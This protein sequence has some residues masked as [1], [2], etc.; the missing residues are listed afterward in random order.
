[1]ANSRGTSAA[2]AKYSSSKGGKVRARKNPLSKDKIN[3]LGFRAI[4]TVNF[5]SGG[6]Y[7]GWTKIN[8]HHCRD[9]RLEKQKELLDK[10]KKICICRGVTA[11]TIM[12]AIREGALSFEALRRIIGTGTGNCKAKRCRSKIDQRIKDYKNTLE[13]ENP[14]TSDPKTSI[15]P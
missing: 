11:A 6:L 10:F 13:A 8:S 3:D 5:R 15:S 12:K 1:M 2:Q 14:E 9:Y 7:W 4:C